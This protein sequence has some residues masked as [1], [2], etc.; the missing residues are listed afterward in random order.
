MEDLSKPRHHLLTEYRTVDGSD[1]NLVDDNLNPTTGSDEVRLTEPNYAP[2]TTN[3]LIDGPNP[4]TISNI[5]SG[6]P[7]AELH[8]PTGISGWSYV[9]GQFLDHDLDLTTSGGSDISIK[10]PSGDPDLADGTTIPMTRANV[11]ST[12]GYAINSITGWID[13]SQVYG[14]DAANASSLRLADGHMKTSDGNNLPI[15]NGKFVAG[16][17]KHPLIFSDVISIS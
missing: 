4:R 7:N 12:T 3:G 6:G 1:N 5:V 11:N 14:S 16:D 17:L 2:C 9:F 13:L 10:V 15:V 8:D